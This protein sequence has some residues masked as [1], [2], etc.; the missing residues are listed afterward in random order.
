MPLDTV[1]PTILTI[2]TTQAE[3]KNS[4]KDEIVL[5]YNPDGEEKLE[6][7]T[8]S[9]DKHDY[10]TVDVPGM[11]L[12]INVSASLTPQE[13]QM[14]IKEAI[15]K[16]PD[17]WEVTKSQVSYPKG[18]IHEHPIPTNPGPNLNLKNPEWSRYVKAYHQSPG[19]QKF[20]HDYADD[21]YK[22]GIIEDADKRCCITPAALAVNFQTRTV[23]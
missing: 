17:V 8:E 23:P 4:Q 10:V 18:S 7:L 2:S 6:K 16:F 15:N 1:E 9:H 20:L 11:D 3:D 12:A 13:R 21:L 5:Q 22:H 19:K 14:V